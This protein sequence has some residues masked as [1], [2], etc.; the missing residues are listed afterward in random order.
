MKG[1]LLNS[2][3]RELHTWCAMKLAITAA[4]AFALAGCAAEHE[5]YDFTPD[6][7]AD[8]SV[9]GEHDGGALSGDDLLALINK[10]APQ[11]LAKEWAPKD[12]VAIDSGLMI[13]GREG[14]L[15]LGVVR[16]YEELAD[17]ASAEAGFDLKIRSAYRSFATQ[18][19]TFDYWVETKGLE[20]AKRFSAEP[21]RSQHQLGTTIDI[22][23]RALDYEVSSD[24]V[25]AAEYTWLSQNAHR[26]GFALSYPKGQEQLTGYG[27]EPWHYRFIG[28]EAAKEMSDSGMHLESYLAAC[29]DLPGD[30]LCLQEELPLVQPNDGFIGGVCETAEDC[31][32]IA[33]DAFCLDDV[34]GYPSGHCTIPCETSCPDRPGANALTFCVGSE[35]TSEYLGT[36]H[37]Q[38]DYELFSV[39]GCREG[40]TCSAATRPAGSSGMVCLPQ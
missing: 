3:V 13:P 30:L 32:S 31:R 6:D 26:F 24:R 33:S 21:G 35:D 37:S 20:H 9:C 17:A 5:T 36:C 16:A 15:R 28:H 22:T 18:C 25:E 1:N 27:F 11:Q 40:Y 4:L 14:L 29:Q 2:L 23:S 7:K 39:S 12:L 34:D 10:D 8:L 19:Q 38:C